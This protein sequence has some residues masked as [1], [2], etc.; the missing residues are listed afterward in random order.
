MHKIPAY[1]DLAAL[2]RSPVAF[3]WDDWDPYASLGKFDPDT[4]ERLSAM[5]DRAIIAFTI[6]C[7]EWVAARLWRNRPEPTPFRFM[8]ACWAY[9]M[10]DNLFWLPPESDEREWQGKEL[11]PI[12]LALMTILNAIYGTE[13]ATS[14]DEGALAEQ[15][16]LRVLPGPS[17]FPEWRREALQRLAQLC[18]RLPTDS[19]GPPVPKEALD[20]A[21]PLHALDA[22]KSV[23][24]FL[25]GLDTDRNP[26]LRRI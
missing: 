17:G 15:I 9:N 1:I 14:A 16:A 26:Y 25:E 19:L 8:E 23:A 20:P 5:S 4:E 2:Q 13:D 3:L 24:D 22:Q 12:D 6:G 18:P 21:M 11:A 7:A 10:T